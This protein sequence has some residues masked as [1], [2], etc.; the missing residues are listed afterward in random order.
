MASGVTVLISIMQKTQ[1]MDLFTSGIAY[2]SNSDTVV[3]IMAF[4]TGL[5]SVYSS[6]SGVVMPAFLPMVPDLA[7]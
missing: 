5:I 6:T 3:P 4:G 1:R 7:Q 2:V